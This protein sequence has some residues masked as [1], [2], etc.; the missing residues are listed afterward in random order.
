MIPLLDLRA[1]YEE[2]RGESDAA[3]R[4]VIDGAAFVGGPEVKGFE[5]EFAAYLGVPRVL[6]VANGTDALEIALQAVGVGPGDRV[7]TV[8]FTFAAT[9]EAIVRCGATPRFV[10]VRADDLTID[11]E[12]AA[13]VIE[14]EPVKAVLPVHLYG[15]GADLD[16][17][18][19]LARAR[20][21]VVIEDAAQAH[22]AWLPFGGRRARAG[23]AGDAAGFSFYPTKNLGAMGDGGAIATTRADV[24]ERA[25]LLANH[26][27][28]E[29][30]RHVIASGRNS[31]L[32]GLQAAVL[33][34]R[35][36]KLDEWNGRRRRIAALYD[37]GLRG[38]PLRLPVERPGYEHVYHQYVVRVANRERVQ[39]AL[40]ARGIGTAIHYPRAL[41][42]QEGFRS[43]GYRG[44][45]FPVAEK[46][47]AE[48]LSLPMSPHLTES[49]AGEVIEAVRRVV[50]GS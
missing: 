49:Q 5:A 20:G 45:Q 9:V 44:G 35:L 26:G 38:L 40:A 32:D 28:A 34:V 33:R 7:L 22:G 50:S 18:V 24:A 19:P 8:P 46:A 16:R 6:G 31:R 15:H 30:Y 47:A 17:L 36:A 13:A 42:E 29:K 25:R 14:R 39:Q 10:D 2:L 48:V 23:A 3:L 11:V 12:Q 1:P 41:H 37:E 43:L 4:R 27:E 21:C